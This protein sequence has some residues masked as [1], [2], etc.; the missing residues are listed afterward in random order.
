MGDPGEVE[1]LAEPAW[2]GESIGG[3]KAEDRIEQVADAGAAGTD[4]AGAGGFSGPSVP[5]IGVSV[6]DVAGGAL[7]AVAQ[8]R[9]STAQTKLGKA[10]DA[11]GAGAADIAFGTLSTLVLGPAGVVVPVVDKIVDVAA[12]K[13]LGIPG[14]S[15]ASTANGAIRG[16]VT[17]AEGA[18]THREKGTASFTAK[19]ETGEYGPIIKKLTSLF[20]G[21][22]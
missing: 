6:G 20:T 12:N 5:G 3:E 4:V 2:L 10:A 15:I 13:A 14:L 1:H 7:T 18:L 21:R 11:G 22:K 9:A 16:G 19:A 17:A 8:A